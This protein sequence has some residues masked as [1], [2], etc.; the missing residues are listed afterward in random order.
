MGRKKG[1]IKENETVLE[2]NFAILQGIYY[3]SYMT[4]NF[5]LRAPRKKPGVPLHYT[6]AKNTP[7]KYLSQFDPFKTHCSFLC[8][9]KN[10]QSVLKG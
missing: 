1:N 3:I 8:I 6:K 2:S 9:Q 7:D 5:L 10:V 4:R